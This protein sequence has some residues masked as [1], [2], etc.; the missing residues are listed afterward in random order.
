M[1]P[2]KPGSPAVM[3]RWRVTASSAVPSEAARRWMVL[4]ALVADP[5]AVRPAAWKAAAIDGVIVAPS[6]AP[7]SSSAPAR[8][9]Y[10]VAC[11]PVNLAVDI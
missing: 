5:M 6:P 10:G 8:Y 11:W 3:A 7:I 4:M 2:P 9:A 1:P